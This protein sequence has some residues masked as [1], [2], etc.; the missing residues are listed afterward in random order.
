MANKTRSDL[1]N[2]ALANLGV[3]A[4]GQTPSAEDFQA[5]DNHVD[6]TVE[7]LNARDVLYIADPDDIPPEWFQPLAVCLADDAAPEFGQPMN[8][9]AVMMAEDKLRLI[10]RG[11]PTGEVLETDYY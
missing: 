5:V 9:Q 7:S 11:K 10:V 4:A 1:V 2:Q 6:Q 8:P 3:L